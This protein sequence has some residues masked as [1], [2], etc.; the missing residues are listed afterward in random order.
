MVQF[1]LGAVAGGVAAWWWRSDI[2]KYMDEKLPDMREKAADR[3]A[4]IEQRAEDAL[5]K[6]KSTIDRMR[7]AGE[8]QQHRTRDMSS[9][10]RPGSY[11][12]GSGV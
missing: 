4:A 11:T 8:G 10:G 6:A 1:I 12:Q 5:G 9:T 2:Q 3:L 7:P